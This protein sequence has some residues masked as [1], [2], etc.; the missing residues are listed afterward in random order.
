MMTA[1]CSTA[2]PRGS[3]WRVKVYAKAKKAELARLKPLRGCWGAVGLGYEERWPDTWEA[4][5]EAKVSQNL[6]CITKV[7]PIFHQAHSI[8][9]H[10]YPNQQIMAHVIDES[11]SVFAGTSR[12]SDF[13]IFHDSLSAW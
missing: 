4:E 3:V 10:P 11:T 13:S 1:T 9:A 8:H 5:L 12:A 2:P 7:S 6:V